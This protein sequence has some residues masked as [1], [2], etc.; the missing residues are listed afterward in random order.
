MQRPDRLTSIH[1]DSMLDRFSF[2]GQLLFIWLL[3]INAQQLSV[4]NFVKVR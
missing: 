2:S 4:E 1:F 3:F